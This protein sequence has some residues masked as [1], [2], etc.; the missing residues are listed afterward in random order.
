[1]KAKIAVLLLLAAA[2]CS[3]LIPKDRS[4]SKEQGNDTSSPFSVKDG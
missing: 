4:A 1:M 2:L 3:T